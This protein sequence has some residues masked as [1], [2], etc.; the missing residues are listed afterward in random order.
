MLLVNKRVKSTARKCNFLGEISLVFAKIHFWLLLLLEFGFLREGLPCALDL[1]VKRPKMWAYNGNTVTT[2][3]VLNPICQPV[4]LEHNFY[5][6]LLQVSYEYTFPTC[7]IV[8]VLGHLAYLQ[9]GH[10]S[11]QYLC[12]NGVNVQ[13]TLSMFLKTFWKEN[14][15]NFCD[16]EGKISFQFPHSERCSHS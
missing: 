14:V 1:I 7:R 10:N 15:L 4:R 9:L 13:C 11:K 8:T 5:H 6:L 16:Q 2:D 3:A 12:P